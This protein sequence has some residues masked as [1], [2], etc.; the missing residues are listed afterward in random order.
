MTRELRQQKLAALIAD[1][2]FD[3]ECELFEASI[4][5]SVCPA[6]CSNSECDYTTEME[7]DQDRGYCEACGTNTVVSA[8]ILGGIL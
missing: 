1:G 5:D 4:M 6:I 3:D 2:D 8:L 7:P